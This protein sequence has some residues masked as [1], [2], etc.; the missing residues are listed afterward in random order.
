MAAID[1][2]YRSQRLRLIS[3]VNAATASVW[4]QGFRDRD[5]VIQEVLRIVYAGQAQTVALVDA[6]MSAKT[7]TGAR[8]LPPQLYTVPVLRGMPADQ[9]YARPFGALGGQLAQGAKFESAVTSGRDSLSRLVRT[10]LQLAQTHSARDWMAGEE[11]IVGYRRVLGGAKNCELCVSAADRTYRKEDL[12]PI[13]EHCSCS[14]EPVYGTEPVASVGTTVRVDDD[15]ELG[16]R[17][18]A[19]SWSDTGPRL[20]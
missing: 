13:H 16:P 19:D 11:R 14:V 8:G 6:Y 3:T 12:M 17:L 1:G 10:D 7:G 4:A 20:L 5:R 9:V 2:A 15:P 18:M